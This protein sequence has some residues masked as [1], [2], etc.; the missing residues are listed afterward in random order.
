MAQR[1]FGPTRAAGT[2]IVE[3]TGGNPIVPGALG[4]RGYAGLL[5]KGPTDE[6]I[7]IASKDQALRR[8]GSY[9]SDSL[10][11]DAIYDS[12][13]VAGGAGGVVA[14]RL[15]DGN[16]VKASFNLYARR[17]SLLTLVGTLSAK[18][19]GRWGGKLKR[20][21]K[22]LSAIGKLT[23]TTLD[24]ED[25]TSFKKD[26]WAGG[27]VQLSG[28]A[29]PTKQYLIVGNTAAG[30]ITV[31][32]DATLKADLQ[33]GTP[34]D[35][36]YYLVRENSGKALSVEIRDG[37]EN[38]DTE[39]G[40]FI[41][42]DGALVNPYPNLS[43]DST[44]SRY[45][46]NLIN[47][48]ESN[49]EVT[50]TMSFAGEIV[51]NV[52]PANIYG[53]TSEAP[54]K[55]V[56]TSLIHD[57]TINSAG[58]GNPTCALGSTSD[59]MLAQ[60]ITITMSSPTS[61]AVVSDRYGALG[62]VTL[63]SAF[64]PTAAT[65]GALKNKWAPTFTITAGV[66][67]LSAADT[68]VINF[69]PFVADALIGG[70]LYPD[71]VNAKR[72]CY[73]ITDNDHKTITVADGSDLTTSG[74][75]GDQFMVTVAQEFE[76]GRD[77]NADVADADYLKAWEPSTS[78]FNRIAGKNLGLVKFA[79]P[80]VTSTAVQKAGVAYSYA[81][82][83]QYRIEIPSGTTSDEG[84]DAYV[85]DTIGRSNYMAVTFPSYAYVTDPESVGE[86]KLK[87]TTR[88]GE[89]HGRE[90]R[91]AEDN[92]GYHRAEAGIDAILPSVIK[93]TTG[94]RIL[95]E[96]LLNPRG[97]PVIRVKQGNFVIWGDRIPAAD[98]TWK[99]K[100]QRETMSYYEQVLAE[101][102]DWIIFS[103]NDA[104]AREMTLQ[105]VR[106]FF[107]A[108]Y[109]K[110]ALDRDYK[111]EDACVLKCD[112]EIN[113]PETKDAGDMIMKITLRLVGV[114]ER[115]VFNISKAGIFESVAP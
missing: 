37:E 73:R 81:K 4:W 57:F 99:W 100:H 58:G 95:N 112:L 21:S 114:V 86:N 90:A 24:T 46:V 91:M 3:Q 64:N 28:T 39:F 23:A 32:S 25:T 93:L 87:L 42:V 7:F 94:N 85:N 52:R 9:I 22:D 31:S 75:D 59:T 108:E 106:Q 10:C 79:T 83:H 110:G 70:Y 63:G 97:I 13:K 56:L 107:K 6:L 14:L 11:P 43:L 77:G 26:E 49:Y 54:T 50:A 51:A 5:E 105:A 48:D 66:S 103:L 78:L 68:L 98:T 115:M 47:N 55:T 34:A 96:E 1:V 33:A 71:K 109:R 74:G 65:G 12:L 69:K 102:F 41:Y 61:G 27:Y 18:N 19:G 84:A 53:I 29:T 89:I 88:T 76:G 72:E 60:K 2:R 92:E 36:R 20:Y 113:T 8:I 80:G 35:L 30:V 45:W 16:E 44:S 111:F 82:N 104:S 17:G 40:L 101:S 67:A 15:T 38:P 62:T